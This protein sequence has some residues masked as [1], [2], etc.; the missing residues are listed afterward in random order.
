MSAM[1]F[2][3]LSA[4]IGFLLLGADHGAAQSAPSCR[5]DADCPD[6][7]A[8]CRRSGCAFGLLDPYCG[9]DRF[10]CGLICRGAGTCAFTVAC[11]TDGDC[12]VDGL[13]LDGVCQPCPWCCAGDADCASGEACV[14]GVCEVAA[15]PAAET[16]AAACL[17]QNDCH[18]WD[19]R[20]DV[21][22]GACVPR[23]AEGET[24]VPPLR[25]RVLPPGRCVADADLTACC[26]DD[27]S[28]LPCPPGVGACPIGADGT[29]YRCS[30]TR[31]SVA[32]APNTGYCLRSGAGVP[33][34]P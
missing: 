34:Q 6:Y 9:R 31:P 25:G 27:V 16:P 15:A 11:N 13:C 33:Q 28:A 22:A 10:L 3:L 29:T 26:R 23:C 12:A 21:A 7:A 4:I 17:S 30:T 19:E 20:C 18:P 32:N 1:R 2:L 8:G 14:D 5:V 24:Y